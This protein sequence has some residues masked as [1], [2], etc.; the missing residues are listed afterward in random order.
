MADTKPGQQWRH[1]WIPITPAAAVKKNHGKKPGKNSM[2]SR[3]VAEAA[4]AAKTLRKNAQEGAGPDGTPPPKWTGLNAGKA[5]SKSSKVDDALRTMAGRPSKAGG[6]KATDD[7]SSF[8]AG[9][10]GLSG[11]YKMLRTGDVVE[12]TAGDHDGKTGRVVG[13]GGDGEVKVDLGG[14]VV[15]VNAG[16]VNQKSAADAKPPAKAAPR[17]S[18]PAK[19]A[20]PKPAPSGGKVSDAQAEKLVLDAVAANSRSGKWTTITAVRR[21]LADLPRDQQDRAMLDL[22]L[23][24]RLDIEPVAIYGDLKPEDRKA[25]LMVGNTP[26]H[27]IRLSGQEAARKPQVQP[28]P[29]AAPK[30]E[31]QRQRANSAGGNVPDTQAK[32][33]VLDAVAAASPRPG[34]WTTMAA[35]RRQLGDLPRDQQDRVILDLMLAGQVDTEPAAIERDLK[36]EDRAAAIMV[37]P[38]PNHQIRLNR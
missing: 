1:G 13:K 37:G 35:V 33:I 38:K 21:Q 10:H 36:P 19:T 17:A 15:T 31:E 26:T 34:K 18:A 6:R 14:K 24:G 16:D 4:E 27:Q 23:A 7:D 22:M 32:K 5:P 8:P 30:R 20:P 9:V 29:A 28:K 25:E 2:L 11:N 3:V 12:V